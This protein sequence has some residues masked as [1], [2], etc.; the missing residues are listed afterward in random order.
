MSHSPDVV[1]LVVDDEVDVVVV[2]NDFK[3]AL[4][5]H[6]PAKKYCLDGSRVAPGIELPQIWKHDI[7][8]TWR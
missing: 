2:L 1:V 7:V 3:R 4:G 5:I 8:L 6:K